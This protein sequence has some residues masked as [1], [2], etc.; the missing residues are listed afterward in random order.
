MSWIL[1]GVQF[2][3]GTVAILAALALA[4]DGWGSAHGAFWGIDAQVLSWTLFVALLLLGTLALLN[5]LKRGG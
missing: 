5:F 2:V 1:R 3:L 4:D